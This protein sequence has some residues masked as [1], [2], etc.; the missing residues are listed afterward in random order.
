[1]EQIADLERSFGRLVNDGKHAQAFLEVQTQQLFR[2]N[3]FLETQIR[4]VDRLAQ[5]CQ[6]E[7][8]YDDD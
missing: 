3:R 6:D 7:I 4:G 1:M 5:W 8:G 2:E